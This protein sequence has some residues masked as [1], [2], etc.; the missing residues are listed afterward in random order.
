MMMIDEQRWK[1]HVWTISSTSTQ[2]FLSCV[3][4]VGEE[5]RQINPLCIEDY[6]CLHIAPAGRQNPVIQFSYCFSYSSSCQRH[7]LAPPALLRTSA[8]FRYHVSC[9]TNT[10]RLKHS[11]IFLY[12]FG[13]RYILC[14]N[15]GQIELCMQPS[16]KLDNNR[17]GYDIKRSLGPKYRVRR[18]KKNLNTKEN[19][20]G[21]TWDDC[22]GSTP[23]VSPTSSVKYT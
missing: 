12:N 19:E 6:W 9:D 14:H 18:R 3:N 1:C 17:H 11:N 5:K 21:L 10:D 16:F 4:V 15:I 23:P 22:A 20:N 2:R 8:S 13:L 7:E